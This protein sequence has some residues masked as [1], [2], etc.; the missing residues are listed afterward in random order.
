MENNEIIKIINK[1]RKFTHNPNKYKL[2]EDIIN[3]IN[4]TK[5][6]TY[7]TL[8]KINN[9]LRR[10][11]AKEQKRE[12]ILLF[13]KMIKNYVLKTIITTIKDFNDNNTFEL[14]RTEKRILDNIKINGEKFNNIEELLNVL[15]EQ[16]GNVEDLFRFIDRNI[17]WRNTSEGFEYWHDLHEKIKEQYYYIEI[18]KLINIIDK[19]ALFDNNT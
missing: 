14:K 10:Y 6:N 13:N 16:Y 4:L 7:L 11:C 17:I 3:L 15:Y 19:N 2:N 12:L 5:A 1:L 18:T 9:I 8:S